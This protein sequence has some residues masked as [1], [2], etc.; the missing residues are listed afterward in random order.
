MKTIS[1]L[2]LIFVIAMITVTGVSCNSK[3]DLVTD[4][5]TAISL[6]KSDVEYCYKHS[7]VKKSDYRENPLLKYSSFT[8]VKNATIIDSGDG[9]WKIKVEYYYITPPNSINLSDYT[10]TDIVDVFSS[11]FTYN[12]SYIR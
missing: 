2:Y 12:Y 6:A 3:H 10:K 11:G 7:V 1:R 9:F 5:E 4:D 8:K